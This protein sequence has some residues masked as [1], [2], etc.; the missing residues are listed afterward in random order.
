MDNFISKKKQKS[1]QEEVVKRRTRKAAK[2]QRSIQGTSWG[3]IMAKR[4]QK[5][6]MRKA[7]RE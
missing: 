3:E 6:E 1:L 5:L 7:L 4:N 2:F